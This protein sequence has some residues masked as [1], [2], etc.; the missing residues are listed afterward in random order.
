MLLLLEGGRNDRLLVFTFDYRF[1]V[2]LETKQQNRNTAS[3]TM[4]RKSPPKSQR[5][6]KGRKRPPVPQPEPESA[7]PTSSTVINDQSSLL[8]DGVLPDEEGDEDDGEDSLILIPSGVYEDE[9]DV[10]DEAGK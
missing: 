2:C 1:W 7:A 6:R 8:P 10:E 9:D 3:S 4:P 5:A